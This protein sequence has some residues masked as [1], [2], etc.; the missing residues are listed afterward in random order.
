MERTMPFISIDNK[1]PGKEKKK[2]KL[3]IYTFNI[4][5]YTRMYVIFLQVY[6]ISV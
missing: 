6:L 3:L 2:L 5:V 4:S 1:V